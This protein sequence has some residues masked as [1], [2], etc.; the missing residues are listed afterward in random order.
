MTAPDFTL[1]IN[2]QPYNFDC[3]LFAK[4]SQKAAELIKNDQF[5]ASVF[6][7]ISE[8]GTNAF[9]AACKYEKFQLTPQIAYELLDLSQEWK[10]PRLNKV[11]QNYIKERRIERQEPPL[12]F[13]D[14]LGNLLEHQKAHEETEED[15]MNVA[16]VF[17]KCLTREELFDVN[18]D[19]L[20]QVVH[21]ANYEEIDAQL[22]LEFVLK[23]IRV[24]P[25]IAVPLLLSLDF[26]K[27][28]KE[29]NDQIFGTQ[30]VHETNIGYFIALQLTALRNRAEKQRNLIDKRL[31]DKSNLLQQEMKNG[32]KRAK[33]E[34]NELF[35]D[36]MNRYREIIEEQRKQII[37][38]RESLDEKVKRHQEQTQIYKQEAA[39]L[40]EELDRQ[41][42]LMNEC[43]KN[44]EKILH[45]IQDELNQQFSN[46]KDQIQRQL[47]DVLE[48]GNE[49]REDTIKEI[50]GPF[51][52]FQRNFVRSK[53][54]TQTIRTEIQ[55]LITETQDMKSVLS[56]KM[57]QDFMRFDNFIRK[58][59]EKRFKVF[60]EVVQEWG[61]SSAVVKDADKQLKSIEKRL[62]K[63]C[64]IR[65]ALS[66]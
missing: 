23:M 10:I 25:F 58:S 47:D 13:V 20:C 27:L 42:I 18:V 40:R 22:Y 50:S 21:Y 9:V 64:P 48:I 19:N 38:I 33:E 62:D 28:N 35:N 3:N 61:L 41:K 31:S 14:Y 57:V 2:K 49:R 4:V 43:K 26:E 52:S 54:N 29:Q 45:G 55:K 24:N 51:N 56:A 36:R 8:E 7:E 32:R 15:F 63:L 5:E 1:F 34:A 59:P 16:R 66:Q 60:D 17:N 39:Q 12:E 44:Y 11:V 65:H 37:I 46:F 6:P 30:E 53:K